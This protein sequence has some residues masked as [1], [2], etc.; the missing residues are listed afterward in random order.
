MPPVSSLFL[1]II[2]EENIFCALHLTELISWSLEKKNPTRTGQ[3]VT[4]AHVHPPEESRRR[5]PD[6]LAVLVSQP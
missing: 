5:E 3:V 6:L 1:I 2:E 4:V